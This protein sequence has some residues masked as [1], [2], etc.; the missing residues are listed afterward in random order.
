MAQLQA[1][2]LCKLNFVCS[3]AFLAECD[4]GH[5]LPNLGLVKP[6]V[7]SRKQNRMPKGRNVLQ[8]HAYTEKFTAID[9]D[10]GLEDEKKQQKILKGGE[11]CTVEPMAWH[12]F[13]NPTEREIRFGVQLEPGNERFEYSLR[14]LY[15]LSGNPA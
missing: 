3:I 7:L 1:R 15:G 11:S 6:R 14:I 8:C 13:F 5:T 4:S 12:C 2:I 9:R 10:L